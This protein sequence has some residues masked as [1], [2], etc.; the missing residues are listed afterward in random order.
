MTRTRRP[1]PNPQANDPMDGPFSSEPRGRRRKHAAPRVSGVVNLYKPVG[2]SSARCV[3]RLRRVFD[4]WKVGHAGTLDPFADGVLVACIGRGTKLVERIMDLPKT[5]RTTIRLGVTNAT[6]DTEQPFEPVAD[7]APV[8]R[9]A[10]ASVAA[11]M[12]GEIEQIPPVFSAVK[13]GGRR[14]YALARGGKAEVGAARHVRIYALDILAYEWPRLTLRIHC[15]R[16][17]YIRAIARD[18]G[19]A[20]G[21]GGCCESLCREAVGPFA[22]DEALRLDQGSAAEHEATL[23]PLERAMAMMAGS[24]SAED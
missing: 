20:L 11:R 17:T 2:E 10:I 6:F 19:A 7:A 18:I 23:I 9:V 22:I 12:H 1:V 24:D 5:Y 16:G 15:G 8:E 4:E 13:I 3:Y 21:V 14:S